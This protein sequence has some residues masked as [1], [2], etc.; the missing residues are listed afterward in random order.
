MKPRFLLPFTLV[1]AVKATALVVDVN[2][3]YKELRLKDGMLFSEV[4]VRSFNTS[5]G[6]AVLLTNSEL[7][8]VRTSLLPD[9]VNARLQGLA[10]V[11][12]KEEQAEERRQEEADRIKTAE[13]AERR[14]KMAE[15]DA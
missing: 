7:I 15:N 9:E 14:Q 8:S 11:Q 6:T 10:P 12:T 1:L 13:K 5:A 4:A 2:L 3:P